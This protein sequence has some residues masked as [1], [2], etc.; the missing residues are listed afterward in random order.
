MTPSVLSIVLIE[1]EVA[2]DTEM[3]QEKVFLKSQARKLSGLTTPL[4]WVDISGLE[5]VS[6]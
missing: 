6:T 5:V 4:V 3:F 1:D 2:L